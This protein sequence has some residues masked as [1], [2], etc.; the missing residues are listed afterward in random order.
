M[1]HDN[2]INK[3]IKDLYLNDYLIFFDKLEDYRN[4]TISGVVFIC[5][6]ESIS[7]KDFDIILNESKQLVKLFYRSNLFASGS[8]VVEKTNT[9]VFITFH[10]SENITF[11]KISEINPINEE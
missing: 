6:N 8:P 2:G 3:D 5:K 9:N 4:R 11:L 1:K 10:E 7:V